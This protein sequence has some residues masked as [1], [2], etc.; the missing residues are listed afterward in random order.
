MVSNDDLPLGSI[1]SVG[2]TS[3]CCLKEDGVPGRLVCDELVSREDEWVRRCNGG[4][5]RRD[6]GSGA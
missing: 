5:T 2:L 6:D 1:V 4:G 3:F